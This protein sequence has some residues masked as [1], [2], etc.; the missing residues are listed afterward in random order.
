MKTKMVYLEDAGLR[1]Q[2][3]ATILAGMISSAP[4][5]DRTKID[6]K[7]WAKIALQWADILLKEPS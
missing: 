4:I 5:C 7:K 2:I 6:R 1:A 3:A